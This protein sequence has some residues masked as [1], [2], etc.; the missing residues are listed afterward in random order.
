MKPMMCTT[1]VPP[2]EIPPHL[3]AP[4]EMHASDN[5]S[6]SPS[7]NS[8]P[9]NSSNPLNAVAPAVGRCELRQALSGAKGRTQDLLVPCIRHGSA[10]IDLMF[11]LS[12][13]VRATVV[14]SHWGRS[15][16]SPMSLHS[17][18]RS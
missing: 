12:S 10:R 1:Q 3:C 11:T 4:L 7:L 14:V 18:N 8:R 2:A 9:L 17:L 6:L 13:D 16:F 5:V 15:I